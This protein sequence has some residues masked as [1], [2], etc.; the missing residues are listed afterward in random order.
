MALGN[1]IAGMRGS[2]HWDSPD[3]RPKHWEEE[4]FRLNARKGGNAKLVYFVS[5]LDRRSIR[6]Y[7]YTLFEDR[8]PT[9]FLTVQGAQGAADV[10]IELT[11]SP[12]GV[13]KAGD[14]WM[15]ERTQEI[16]YLTENPTTGLNTFKNVVRHWGNTAAGLGM[17]DGDKLAWAGSAYGEGTRSP[18]ALSRNPEKV[19]NYLQIE[20]ET[21]KITG[22]AAEMETRPFKD[23][24]ARERELALERY[25]NKVEWA[26]IF[27]ARNLTTDAEGNRLSST[28]GIFRVLTSNVF[29]FST[30]GVNLTDFEDDLETVFKYG[31]QEKLWIGGR[32][33]ITIATRLVSRS[34]MGIY[35]LEDVDRKQSYGL[36]LKRFYTPHGEFILTPH[37]LMTRST[38]FTKW[39]FLLDPKYLRLYHL[40][41]RYT[42][43]HSNAEANDED[44][45]KGYYQGE[46]GLGLALQEVHA[47]FKGMNQ[48]VA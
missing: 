28:N 21:A 17:D 23:A 18:L 41:N 40:R 26:L 11:G 30:T 20:K 22:S 15:N 36:R 38:E 2:G 35:S 32:R 10:D 44:A 39:S 3:M 6:D 12:E 24:W 5:M 43:W 27:G 37:E 25:I 19:Y 34:T 46:L 4:A 7:E 48:Y 1:A 45:K 14:Q 42:K 47:V 9:M 8:E 29:D 16:I 33:T 13:T 31:S